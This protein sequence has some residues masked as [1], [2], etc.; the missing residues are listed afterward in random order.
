[1]NNILKDNIKIVYGFCNKNRGYAYLFG[2]YEDYVSEMVAQ[3]CAKIDRW[4]PEKGELST[5]VNIILL[6]HIRRV[7]KKLKDNSVKCVSF[8]ALGDQVP[9]DSFDPTTGD[10]IY[11][12]ELVN[13]LSPTAFDYYIKKLSK[14]ECLQKYKISDYKF[15]KILQNT[16]ENIS[17]IVK[18]Y[19][20][21]SI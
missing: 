6:N 1:M 7:F 12:K 19:N 13:G 9:E 15:Y 8:E 2:G 14:N 21:E 18:K 10:S 5:F 16:K 20:A 17:K 4:E 3:Y 11:Y